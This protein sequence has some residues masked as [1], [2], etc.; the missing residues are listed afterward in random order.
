VERRQFLCEDWIEGKV[1][2]YTNSKGEPIGVGLVADTV[3]ASGHFSAIATQGQI[4]MTDLQGALSLNFHPISHSQTPHPHQG[5]RSETTIEFML[6]SL[7]QLSTQ[8]QVCEYCF[9]QTAWHAIHMLAYRDYWTHGLGADRTEINQEE[10]A[11]NGDDWSMP[12][13]Q[14][15][16]APASQP[17]DG[18]KSRF[19]GNGGDVAIG[20]YLD[21]YHEEDKCTTVCK[22]LAF[23]GL[24]PFSET[25]APSTISGLLSLEERGGKML[26]EEDGRF[27]HYV[28][29]GDVDPNEPVMLVMCEGKSTSW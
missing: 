16:T 10:S 26:Q 27:V 2:K 14:R 21:V 6:S 25:Q 22:R 13:K 18:I 17:L 12:G 8:V 4:L 1:Q 5:S 9:T 7:T 23:K 15:H 11:N 24:D 20:M 29:A 19:Y 28:P 3:A